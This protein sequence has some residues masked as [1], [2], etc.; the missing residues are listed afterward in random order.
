[1][2]GWGDEAPLSGH[3]IRFTGFVPSHDLPAL[4]NLCTVFAFPSIMEGY[5]L[6]VIEA[7]AHGAPVVTSRGTSTEEVAGGAAIL[8][9]PLDVSSIASGIRESLAARDAW[10]SRS[11]DRAV[12]V[13][14]SET[15]RATFSA[16]CELLDEA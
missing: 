15:A 3:D 11:R 5:G 2:E 14:W 4:Y 16:Y 8:V 12:Q 7:M 10:S 13:P 9:D 1:M 6:P